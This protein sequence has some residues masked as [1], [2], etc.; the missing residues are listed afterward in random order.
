LIDSCYLSRQDFPE[1]I[2]DENVPRKNLVRQIS[3]ASNL[4]KM[5]ELF[6]IVNNLLALLSL[7]VK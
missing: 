3:Q 4:C 1:E 7:F 6:V 5:D 2:E